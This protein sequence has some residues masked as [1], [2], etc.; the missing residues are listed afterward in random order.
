MNT[1]KINAFQKAL[2]E[3]AGYWTE[4]SM[5]DCWNRA[6]TAYGEKEFVV[7]DRGNRY[8]YKEMDSAADILAAWL[9][10]AGISPGDVVSYQ[11]PPRSE[12]VVI[13]IACL[14]AGAVLAP[15][16]MCFMDEELIELLNLMGSKLHI[17]P[18]WHRDTNRGLMLANLRNSVPS[19]EEV[20]LL[21]GIENR[22]DGSVSFEEIMSGC[23]PL[24]APLK[25]LAKPHGNDL[26]V[27]LCTSGTTRKH[28]VVMLTHN[29]V[30]FSEEGFNRGFGLTGDDIIF[31]PAPLSHATGFHHGIISPML[32]GA[33]LVLQERFCCRP[34]VEIMNREKCTYSMG[35]T[36]FAYD[37]LKELDK[38]ECR[39]EHLRFYLCGGAPVPA[40]MI[41]KAWKDFGIRICEV[42]GSTESVPHAFVRPEEAIDMAGCWSGRAMDGV[43]IRVVDGLGRDVPAGQIGEEISRGPNVFVGYLNDRASTD[44]VL[45]DDGWYYSGDLCISDVFGNIKIVGR[46]KDLIVRGGENLNANNINNNLEGCP[47]IRDH[48]VVGMPDE[49]LGERICAYVVP[50]PGSMEVSKEIIITYLKEKRI[51]RRYWPER[52]EIIDEI[53]R[54]ESG[55]VMKY[56]LMEE[57]KKRMSTGVEM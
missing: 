17:S 51:P 15:L 16:G 24:Q 47:G 56:L 46:K 1:L 52:M 14:K 13:T 30:I 4:D 12:F 20:V 45:D 32:L 34:A 23:F 41:D 9:V 22:K 7:D 5:L 25:T 57:L 44:S 33:K 36:P 11:L 43:E 48:A 37:I 35:A 31:M 38:G 50:E 2:Y 55:K 10:Q 21:D 49:R 54:T 53:P 8:T 19:L 6:L 40:E 26:A 39:L 29:N 18:A 42:Y 3:K 27:L 28:R